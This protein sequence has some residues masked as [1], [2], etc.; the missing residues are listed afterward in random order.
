MCGQRAVCSG[1]KSD[2]Q[3]GSPG[4]IVQI[5]NDDIV[6]SYP[7]STGIF[8]GPNV[9]GPNFLDRMYGTGFSRTQFSVPHSDC[10]HLVWGQTTPP[11]PPNVDWWTW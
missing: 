1:R 8:H 5:R 11:F 4:S 2:R 7:E 9:P 6:V 10:W 3:L